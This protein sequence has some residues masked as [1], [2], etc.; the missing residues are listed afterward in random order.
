M[1][2]SETSV[3]AGTAELI[4]ISPIEKVVNTSATIL[5]LGLLP[6]MAIIVSIKPV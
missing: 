3:C 4:G 2:F 5:K 6:M 1:Y